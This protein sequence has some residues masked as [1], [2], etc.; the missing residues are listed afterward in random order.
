MTCHLSVVG[1]AMLF[2]GCET[3]S[4]Q[5]P[6]Y[7]LCLDVSFAYFLD[8]FFISRLLKGK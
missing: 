2:Q 1:F 5:F 6:I 7:F 8:I 4:V 3:F